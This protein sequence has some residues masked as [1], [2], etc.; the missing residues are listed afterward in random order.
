M[1]RL[2]AGNNPFKNLGD[3]YQFKFTG[4][5]SP[6]SALL[7]LPGLCGDDCAN[8][9]GELI[10]ADPARRL[11]AATALKHPWM[12]RFGG[13][14]PIPHKLEIS[15]GSPWQNENPKYIISNKLRVIF[16]AIPKV[17]EMLV[18]PGLLTKRSYD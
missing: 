3:V 4:A 16:A 2:I 6:R 15:S 11:G 8:F 10:T 1:Y 13:R 5:P 9:V 14:D 17:H 7:D 12:L 18:Q